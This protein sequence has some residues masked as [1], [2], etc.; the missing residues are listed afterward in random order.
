MLGNILTFEQL[1]K[2]KRL[3]VARGLRKYG[4]DGNND[5]D[6]FSLESYGTEWFAESERCIL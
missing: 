3:S 2:I 1:F 4:D 5:A 6:I